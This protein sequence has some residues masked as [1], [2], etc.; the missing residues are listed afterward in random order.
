MQKGG[1]GKLPIDHDII[2]KTSPQ[3]AHGATKQP[4]P[5]VVFAVLGPIR[6]NIHRQRKTRAH[7]AELRPDGVDSQRSVSCRFSSSDTN[8]TPSPAGV[9]N[10]CSRSEEHT[11][12]L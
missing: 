3:L 11:S 5:G 1:G 4:L 6:F 8:R 7:H 12:E 9:G 2:R 10:R